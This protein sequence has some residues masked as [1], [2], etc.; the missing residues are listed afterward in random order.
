MSE[1]YRIRG[2]SLLRAGDRPRD[3]AMAALATAVSIARM[4]GATLLELNA[5]ASLAVAS[6]ADGM[7]ALRAFLD[8]LPPTFEAPRL[9][10]AR[11]I[12]AA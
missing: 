10:E 9:D 2:E 8:A 11:R 6:A 1:L 12:A 5:H 7:T 3:E 4:Q